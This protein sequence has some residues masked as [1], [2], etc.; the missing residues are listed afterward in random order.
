MRLPCFRPLGLLLVFVLLDTARASVAIARVEVGSEGTVRSCLSGTPTPA[1]W[2]PLLLSL[3]PPTPAFPYSSLI[4]YDPA[5]F[6]FASGELKEIGKLLSAISLC[7]VRVGEPRVSRV[8]FLL[9]G[10]ALN[11]TK[12][13]EYPHHP[14]GGVREKNDEEWCASAGRA[15]PPCCLNFILSACSPYTR[16]HLH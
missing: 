9:G 3:G 1:S 6:S 2:Y 4:F 11:C 14:L 12:R 7:T 13:D 16:H 15:G 10:S 8:P 5:W